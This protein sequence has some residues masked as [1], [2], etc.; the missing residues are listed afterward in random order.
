MAGHGS[1]VEETLKRIQTHKGVLG[2][3]IVNSDGIVIRSTLDSAGSS[4]NGNSQSNQYAALITQLAAKARSA[5][6]DLD[7]QNDL[8]FLRI[9]SKKHE[10]MVAPDNEYMLIVIQNPSTEV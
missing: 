5:V 9:R 1:E 8:T 2:V 10:I 6:R 3:V 7:P 4:S